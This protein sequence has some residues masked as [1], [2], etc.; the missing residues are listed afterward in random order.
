MAITT[1]T[2]EV[3]VGLGVPF[4]LEFEA[5]MS[6]AE[7]FAQSCF[8]LALDGLNRNGVINVSVVLKLLLYLL[9]QVSTLLTLSVH[10]SSQGNFVKEEVIGESVGDSL[11][12]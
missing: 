5:G 6:D 8:D 1:V 11:G 2:V 3:G 9:S 4:I 10:D 7:A 12:M